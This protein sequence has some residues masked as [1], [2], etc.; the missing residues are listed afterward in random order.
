MDFNL[1]FS[2]L[3]FFFL[4]TGRFA[5]SG[6]NNVQYEDSLFFPH[7]LFHFYNFFLH[8]T[9]TETDFHLFVRSHQTIGLGGCMVVPHHGPRNRLSHACTLLSHLVLKRWLPV[10]GG[11]YRGA[12]QSML[13]KSTAIRASVMHVVIKST[14]VRLYPH[15]KGRNE[16]TSAWTTRKNLKKWIY[17]RENLS[18]A[19]EL[20]RRTRKIGELPLV[21]SLDLFYLVR[22]K[23][24]QNMF[25]RLWMEYY[26]P[27]ILDQIC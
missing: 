11:Q 16:K 15:E 17:H 19:S 22:R 13:R 3:L 24:W 12:H 1:L 8:P 27:P 9:S 23:L 4:V 26:Y 2:F 10:V 20:E 14:Q 7:F 5:A 6:N 18:S 21:Q 25:R